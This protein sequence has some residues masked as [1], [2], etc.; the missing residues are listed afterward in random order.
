MTYANF[1]VIRRYN[2]SD[3]YALSV[4]VLASRISAQSNQF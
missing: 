3:L 2:P 1:A 4:G